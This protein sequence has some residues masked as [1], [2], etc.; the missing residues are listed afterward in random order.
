MKLKHKP[1]LNSILMGLVIVGAMSYKPGIAS[2]VT[3]EEAARLE[4][5]T[6]TIASQSQG[7][8]RSDR[9]LFRF[10]YSSKDFVIDN[11]ISTPSNGIDAP[12]AAL[13]IWTKQH[14]QKIR[15][16]AYEGGT[17]YPANVSI[18]VYNNP[19]KLA[20]QQWVK[21]SNQFTMSRDFKIARIAGKTGIKFQSSGLYENES[22]V[23]IN[24]KDSRI[25]VVS[26]S[27]NGTNNDA[28]YRRAYQQ[29]ANSFTFVNR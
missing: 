27:K 19:K 16:G 12:L 4:A 22:V 18:R 15:A 2:S 28:I 17:E 21:Q 11:N 5:S 10:T 20:L 24:P 29:I 13:D 25:I 6:A 7:V 26:L 9:F 14:A 8:Y 1:V 3:P 23:F